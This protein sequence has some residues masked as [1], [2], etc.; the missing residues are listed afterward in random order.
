MKKDE[1]F[2]DIQRRILSEEFA[3]GTWLV[4][5]DLGV[6]YGISRTPIREILNKL[7]LLGLITVQ[8]NRGY[9]VRQFS[10]QDV[11]EI[12]NA[13]IAI[14]S[15]CARYACY[16]NSPDIPARIAELREKLH[17]LDIQNEGGNK[18]IEVGDQVHGL[19]IELAHNRYLQEFTY[20][21]SSLMKLTRNLTKK[22]TTIEENSRKDHLLILQALENKDGEL[23]AQL[24][25]KH[26]SDT[27]KSLRE[28]YMNSLTSFYA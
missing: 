18:A 22:R 17:A 11:V 12:F 20:K 13:R 27:C 28:I 2:E 5:R 1:I 19:L 10:F 3:P 6:E 9:Q 25:E 14:E 16:S 21:L 24:M 15:A 4:E 23:C 8:N 26:L 7:V